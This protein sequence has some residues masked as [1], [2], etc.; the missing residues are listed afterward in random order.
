V[1]EVKEQAKTLR[2]KDGKEVQ[3]PALPSP[4]RLRDT[5]TTIA[6]EAGV[7]FLTIQVLT[8]HRP[9]KGDVTAGYIDPQMAHLRVAQEKV[10][11]LVLRKI[12]RRFPGY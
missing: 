2:D 1:Q 3:R 5:Y 8:N 4:H 10:S 12:G 9:P 6:H 11:A 7:D